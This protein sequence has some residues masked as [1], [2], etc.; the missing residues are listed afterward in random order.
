MEEKNRQTL[1]FQKGNVVLTRIAFFIFPFY[2]SKLTIQQCNNFLF[3]PCLS[4]SF[5]Y[6]QD[7]LMKGFLPFYTFIRNSWLSIYSPACNAL[8]SITGRQIS[9]TPFMKIF[10]VIPAYNEEKVIQDVIREVRGAG[11]QNILVV[12]DGSSDNTQA[13]AAELIGKLALRHKINRGKGGA[14]KTGIEA[15]KLLGA[16][17]IVTIDGDGQHDPVDIAKLIEPIKQQHCDVVLGTR[18]LAPKGMPAWKIAANHFGNFCTW[19]LFGLWVTDSQS[20]FRAYSRHA[21]EVI[22]T[23]ADRYEYDSEVIREI[24]I[25][26]LKFK[27]IPIAVRYTDY[28]MGKIHKQGFFNGLKTLY[29]MIWNLIS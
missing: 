18:L 4:P 26:K 19:L 3:M 7:T 11:Y 14:T 22:N 5:C 13:K 25:Y 10:I 16:D 17:I 29:K 9:I 23:R 6:N 21:A 27:E 15:A 2:S 20:G 8:R 1:F 24:Y 28:S 12:D